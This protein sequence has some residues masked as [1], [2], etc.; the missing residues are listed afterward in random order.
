MRHHKVND[1]LE[2]PPIGLKESDQGWP[3]PE[4]DQ[5]MQQDNAEDSFGDP[6]GD[7]DSYGYFHYSFSLLAE[8]S[9]TKN[10]GNIGLLW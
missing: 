2:D 4:T 5:G 8:A 6:F 9:Y 10:L 7:I 3:I 1:C